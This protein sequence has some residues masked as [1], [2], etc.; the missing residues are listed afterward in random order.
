MD[1]YNWTDSTTY[2]YFKYEPIKWRIL[3][4]DE[5]KALLLA[6]VALDDQRYHEKETGVTW[7]ASTIRRW[8]NGTFFN[9]AFT[10]GERL[11][12]TAT[13]VVNADNKKWGTEEGNTT[14]D[15]VFLLSEDEVYG[16][17]AAAYENIKIYDF[18][19]RSFNFI[20]SIISCCSLLHKW[21]K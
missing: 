17:A 13:S 19:N 20:I 3:K 12:V 21:S 16:D 9:N 18:D 2:H 4:A 7:E 6:D 11:A 14:I 5:N 1:F 15:K 8:L 10:G